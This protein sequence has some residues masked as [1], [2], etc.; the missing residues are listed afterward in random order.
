MVTLLDKTI[1]YMVHSNM[2]AAVGSVFY[3]QNSK[4]G[5]PDKNHPNL[6]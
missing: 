1:G 5:F 3:I 2:I 6:R 4:S